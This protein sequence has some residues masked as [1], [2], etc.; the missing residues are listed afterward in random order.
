ML[1]TRN[2]KINKWNFFHV[3]IRSTLREFSHVDFIVKDIGRKSK[4]GRH[5]GTIEGWRRNE[6][7]RN[8]KCQKHRGDV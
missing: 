5:G 8:T 3:Q 7:D 6:S 2:L 1:N 4:S